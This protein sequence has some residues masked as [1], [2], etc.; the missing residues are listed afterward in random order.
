MIPNIAMDNVVEKHIK[1]LALSGQHEWEIGGRKHL[2][3]EAR[4]T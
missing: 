3:F 2:E 4:K 1:A